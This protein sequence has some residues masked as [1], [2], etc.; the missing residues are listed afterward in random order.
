MT[1]TA[2]PLDEIRRA[3]DGIAYELWPH[4]TTRHACPCGRASTR[5]GKCWR[6]ELDEINKIVEEMEGHQ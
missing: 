2:D 4:P 3:A 1:D 6:C 5:R